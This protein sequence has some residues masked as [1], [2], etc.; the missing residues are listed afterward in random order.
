MQLEND[1]GLDIFCRIT[2]Q[3]CYSICSAELHNALIPSIGILLPHYSS[4]Q[5]SERLWDL[6]GS[7]SGVWPIVSDVLLQPNLQPRC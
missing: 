4:D 6:E 3:I 7:F 1:P 5:W 2:S